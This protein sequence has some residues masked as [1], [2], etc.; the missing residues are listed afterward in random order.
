M[1]P[2]ESNQDTNATGLGLEREL[3]GA[4]WKS[5]LTLRLEEP[6]HD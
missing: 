4:S 6:N 3:A 1:L 2:C 5:T